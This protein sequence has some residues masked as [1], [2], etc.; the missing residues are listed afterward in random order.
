MVQKNFSEKVR[1]LNNGSY[2]LLNRIGE[3]ADSLHYPCYVVGGWVRDLLLGVKNK[4]IDVVVVG[5]GSVMA[6][7]VANIIGGKV[8]VYESYGTAQI[9]SD[10]G[11]EV[12]FVG[13]RKEFY[14]RESRNPIVENGTLKDDMDRRDLTI[15][16]MA[17]CLNKDNFGDFIDP[18]HG[19]E[20]LRDGIIRCVGNA[21][22]RFDEDPLRMLRCI[23]FATRF[24]FV[25]DDD[26]LNA[27]REL[28]DRLSI[29]TKERILAEVNK[30]M[31]CEYPDD[32]IALLKDTEL[33]QY[34]LPELDKAC[35]VEE[36]NGKRHKDIFAHSLKVLRNVAQV[37]GNLY[38]RWAALLHD[39]GKVQV[40]EFKDGNW[41]FENHAE[42]GAKMIDKIFKRLTFP[43]DERMQYIKTLI[44]L[45]MRPMQLCEDGVTDAAVRRLL[46]DAGDTIDDLLILCNADITSSHRDK[47]EK[48][49]KNY[50]FLKKRM[51]ELEES[52]RLRNF[53]PPV[54]G[55][56]IMALFDLTPSRIVGVLKE[57]VKDAILDGIIPNEH[58]AAKQYVI[59]EFN[60][61]KNQKL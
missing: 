61:I 38:L 4:D 26:T 17:I 20:D 12:E 8:T 34:V 19:Y 33:L 10:D 3:V 43:L 53:Q 40:K 13:A 25:I 57:K 27:M 9:L 45:H 41:T 11:T 15:N 32:A 29:I 42:V 23:R 14:H 30:M 56:E 18:Y 51:V 35:G 47:V 24:D 59:E 54:D 46:F 6:K 7:E 2:E 28:H 55:N 36:C 49:Q 1:Q 31:Q 39:V 60:K 21:K 50:E 58:D 16:D 22:E 37:S 44:R 48:F 52:D 5:S